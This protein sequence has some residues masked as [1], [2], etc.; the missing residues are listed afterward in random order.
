MFVYNDVK[1]NTT[2]THIAPCLV[3]PHP[4]VD[5]ADVPGW[6]GDEGRARVHDG[7]AAAAAG[8][9]VPVEGDAAATHTGEGVASGSYS[10]RCSL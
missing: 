9:R 10:Q 7:Q 6:P 3:G 5:V 4:A 8:H 2:S 1:T